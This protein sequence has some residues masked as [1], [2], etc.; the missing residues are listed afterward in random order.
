MFK[1]FTV[2]YADTEEFGNYTNTETNKIVFTDKPLNKMNTRDAYLEL[3]KDIRFSKG[4]T[5][6]R[7]TSRKST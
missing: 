2:S 7:K 1:I 6:K 4:N 3:T 5:A